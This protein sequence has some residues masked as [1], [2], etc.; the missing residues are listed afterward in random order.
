MILIIDNHDS[1]T[2][3]LVQLCAG[4][5]ADIVVRRNDD[6]GVDEVAVLAPAGIILSPGPGHPADA[7]VTVD[8][9]KRFGGVTPILGVCLGHQAIGVAYGGRV[10][11]AGRPMHGKVSAIA[12]TG[13][14]LFH[15]IPDPVS[16]T[17]YHSLTLEPDT[18]P[19]DL[20]VVAWTAGR[21]DE[22]QSVRHRRHP[23]F[24]VQFHPESVA[25][26]HGDRLLANFIALTA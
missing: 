12:H 6:V 25:S 9:V 18:V 23:V 2:Y 24:G 3:N 10:V 19:V 22:I 1:F 7:G 16:M 11:R 8:V 5:G 17:R 21:N 15:G 13:A 4:L 20:E 26:V 14:G